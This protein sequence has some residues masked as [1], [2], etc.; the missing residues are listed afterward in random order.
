MRQSQ[1]PTQP[2]EKREFPTDDAAAPAR[3]SQH[4]DPILGD[5]KGVQRAKGLDNKSRVVLLRAKSKGTQANLYLE[6][7]GRHAREGAAVK[8]LRSRLA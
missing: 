2:K 5:K 6:Q 4:Y 7:S 3:H 8:L 1:T